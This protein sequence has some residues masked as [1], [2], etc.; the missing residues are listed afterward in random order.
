LGKKLTLENPV[1]GKGFAALRGE[2]K[3]SGREKAFV[4]GGGLEGTHVSREVYAQDPP[5][6]KSGTRDVGKTTA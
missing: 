1:R 2:E 4:Y 5:G 3:K 6:K